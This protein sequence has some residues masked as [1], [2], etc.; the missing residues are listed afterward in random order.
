MV[1]RT[2]KGIYQFWVI[3][4]VFRGFPYLSRSVVRKVYPPPEPTAFISPGRLLGM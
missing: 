4:E 1:D 2:F 3:V